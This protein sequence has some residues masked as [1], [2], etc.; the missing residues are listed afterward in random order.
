MS[1]SSSSFGGIARALLACCVVSL[2]LPAHADFIIEDPGGGVIIGDPGGGGGP[3]GGGGDFGCGA[4]GIGCDTQFSPILPS[5]IVVFD[6]VPRSEER[7]VGKGCR[8][9]L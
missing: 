4:T 3:P 5:E 9:R 2:A 8:T 6:G 7:R 1:Q